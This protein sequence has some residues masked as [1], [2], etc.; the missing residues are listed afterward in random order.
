MPYSNIDDIPS[1]TSWIV[2]F[3][4]IVGALI[5]YGRRKD[6]T[7]TQK[8]FLFISD[9]ISSVMLSVI[10]FIT[11]I[12]FGGT[13]ILAVGIAGFVAHQGTRAVYLIELIIA[14]K[15][16]VDINKDIQE[17]LK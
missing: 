2:F 8:V 6:K 7:F 12:G 1:K 16:N 17:E 10:T 5:N 9:L 14:K 15:F 3:F 13:E 11:V 4:G